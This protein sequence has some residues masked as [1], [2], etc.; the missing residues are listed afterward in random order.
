MPK[1]AQ[2]LGPLPFAAF[3]FGET[4]NKNICCHFHGARMAMRTP[5]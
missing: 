4:L 1:N 2:G 5:S 3:G